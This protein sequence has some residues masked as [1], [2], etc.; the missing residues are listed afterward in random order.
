MHT[1][2]RAH[3]EA[4]GDSA[5]HED[6]QWQRG[7]LRLPDL[8]QGKGNQKHKDQHKQRNDTPIAP[9]DTVSSTGPRQRKGAAKGGPGPKLT[10][11]VVPPHCRARHRRMTPRRRASRPGH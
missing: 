9:L 10:A 2:T 3:P 7:L 4:G 5:L 11:W 8:D 6:A 1:E